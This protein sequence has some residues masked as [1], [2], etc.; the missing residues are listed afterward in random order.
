MQNIYDEKYDRK[1]YYWGKKPSLLCYKIMKL[2]PPDKPLKLLDIGC[3]EGRNAVFFARNGYDVTA[4]D[5]SPKG[6][7]KTQR[8][9]DETSAP[10]NVFPADINKFRLKEKFDIIFSTGALHYIPQEL[11]KEIFDNHKLFT[12]DNGLCAYSVF[13]TKPFIPTAPD[14][15][16]TAQKWL[17]GEILTYYHDWLIQFCHE[18]IFDCNSA[19]IPHKHAINRIIAR[20][21]SY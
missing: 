4:F 15:E 9:A 10:I 20:K 1:E 7:E 17:S 16:R 8:Y 2:M 13:V 5:S 12:N 3:G 19:G 14:A 6:V 21:T 11:R 18:E